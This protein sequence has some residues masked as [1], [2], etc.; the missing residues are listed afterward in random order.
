MDSII[1]GDYYEKR[2][3][4]LREK[5]IKKIEEERSLKALQDALKETSKI[6]EV[7]SIEEVKEPP[8]K[9]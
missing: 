6:P 4:E 8:T 1:S 5:E 7:K 9:N 2:E 3:Q